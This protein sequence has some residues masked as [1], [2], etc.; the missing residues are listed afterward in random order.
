MTGK[1]KA[2]AQASAFDALLGELETMTKAL[3][4]DD[5]SDKKIQAAAECGGEG[6]E[7][8]DDDDDKEGGEV[9]GKSMMVTIDG[10]QVEAQDGTELVKSLIA[11]CD[12]TEDVIAKA[13]T[14][15]VNLV[16]AQDVRA[17]AQDELIKSLQGDLKR[18]GGEGKGRK[19]L[20]SI[21]ESTSVLAKAEDTGLSAVEFMAKANVA[22]EAKRISGA[23][24][25][26]IDVALRERKANVI[27][28]SL[29]AKV[30][31]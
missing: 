21:T 4:A 7:G 13:L 19:T 1:A 15:V 26:F 28:Q 18:I 12:D 24:L 5:G 10:K 14:S 30:L 8:E 22:F 27:D 20:L 3:P 23:D 29:V 17:K 25:N 11:R 2:E 16:K 6:G 31:A 9:M